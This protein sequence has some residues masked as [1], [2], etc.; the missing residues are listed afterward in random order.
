MIDSIEAR[1][2]ARDSVHLALKYFTPNMP[3][4]DHAKSINDA[5]ALWR[6]KQKS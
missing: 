6:E 5:L 3:T 2:V 1:A 4:Q